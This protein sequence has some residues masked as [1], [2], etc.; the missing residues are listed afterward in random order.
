MSAECCGSTAH[1]SELRDLEYRYEM[2]AVPR[3]APQPRADQAT[4]GRIEYRRLENGAWIVDNWIIR[5]PILTF[6]SRRTYGT[7]ASHPTDLQI[8]AI[9]EVGGGVNG[10]AAR[11]S[12]PPPPE[13]N[14]AGVEGNVVGGTSQLPVVG[15]ELTLSSLTSTRPPL[16]QQTREGGAF[17]FENVQPGAYE[18][19]MT[20][21]EFDTVF[22]TLAAIPLRLGPG[23]TETLTITLPDPEERRVAL[24]RGSNA[25]SVIVHGM[26]IDSASGVPVPRA[27]VAAI[28]RAVDTTSAKGGAA[29][30]REREV[31]TDKTGQYVFCDLEPTSEVLVASSAESRK[32]KRAPGFALREGGIYMVNFRIAP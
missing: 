23:N 26:V 7:I 14:R 28:W 10:I 4:T 22:I 24:C 29:P 6:A 2:P 17:A 13:D 18:L 32:S 9:W 8:S 1:S 25:K 11:D 3:G 31:F 12:S 27:K 19:R 16:V 5:V 15:A 21:I 30:A 20:K